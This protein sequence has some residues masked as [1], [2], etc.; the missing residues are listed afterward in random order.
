MHIFY[1]WYILTSNF[2]KSTLL[3]INLK[4]AR[5][6]IDNRN[7]NGEFDRQKYYLNHIRRGGKLEIVT[8]I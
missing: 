3:F 5:M 2:Q 1:H 6:I 7:V 8:N 4:N